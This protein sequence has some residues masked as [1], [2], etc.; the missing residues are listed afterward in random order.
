MDKLRLPNLNEYQEKER[1]RKVQG[2]GQPGAGARTRAGTTTSR[3]H[4]INN[5]AGSVFVV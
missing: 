4:A 2:H 1:I 3:I 5:M